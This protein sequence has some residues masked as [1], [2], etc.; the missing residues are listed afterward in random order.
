MLAASGAEGLSK[1]YEGYPALAIVGGELPSVYVKEVCLRLLQLCDIPVVVLGAEGEDAAEMLEAGADAC[2]PSPLN[3]A[4][5]V[6]RVRSLLRRSRRG[7][8]E[9]S[10]V[11]IKTYPRRCAG[12]GVRRSG[13]LSRTEFRLLLC[14]MLNEGRLMESSELISEAWGGK[15]VSTEC[16]KFY[17]GRLRKKMAGAFAVQGQIVNQRGVGYCYTRDNGGNGR[18]NR[19]SL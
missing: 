11:H 19:V 18:G 15:R 3:L 12:G 17:V 16:L 9:S 14:L 13:S 1:L 4:E 7:G 6:A 10:G 8:H 5:L 2:M